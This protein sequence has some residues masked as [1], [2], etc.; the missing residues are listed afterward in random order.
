MEMD[1]I[2][3]PS[4][5]QTELIQDIIRARVELAQLMKRIESHIEEQHHH[6][7][8]TDDIDEME[9]IQDADPYR[10]HADAKHALQSGLMF[11]LR[12]V[13]QPTTF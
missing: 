5:A 7:K 11:A 12:A 2:T 3:P 8:A 9:R 4:F 1:S 13:S 6:A 10:W